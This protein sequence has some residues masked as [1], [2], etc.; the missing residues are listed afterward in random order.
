M[1]PETRTGYARYWLDH[2]NPISRVKSWWFWNVKLKRIERKQEKIREKE[3]LEKLRK[4]INGID[5]IVL[6]KDSTIDF[7]LKDHDKE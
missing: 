2:H 1:E 4:V 6:D 3:K 7:H 5:I